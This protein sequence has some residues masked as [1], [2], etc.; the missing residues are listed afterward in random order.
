MSAD[1][2]RIVY[3]SRASS[4]MHDM[5]LMAL[6]DQSRQWNATADVTGALAY[7]DQR[8][9]QVLE[10]NAVVVEDLLTRIKVDPRN[11]GLITI[12]YAPALQRLFAGW[13][14]GW[15][16]EAEL[17]HAGFDFQ[18]LYK[19]DALCGVLSDIFDHFRRLGRA[20]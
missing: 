17:R 19:Q 20:S 5:D 15:V 7:H 18:L 12:S 14:M 10:G 13:S 6:L 1:L 11:Y 4:P 9:L 8:F 3:V 2:F 16:P